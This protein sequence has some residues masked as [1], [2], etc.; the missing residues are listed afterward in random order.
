MRRNVKSSCLESRIMTHVIF[1][2]A[3]S[4][5][6]LFDAPQHHQTQFRDPVSFYLCSRTI[7][8]LQRRPGWLLFRSFRH[9]HCYFSPEGLLQ[10]MQPCAVVCIWMIP[11]GCPSIS[12]STILIY[13][14]HPSFPCT[15]RLLLVLILHR[16]AGWSAECLN[17]YLFAAAREISLELTTHPHPSMYD[18]RD[19]CVSYGPGVSQGGCDLGGCPYSR[20][21]PRSI[22]AAECVWLILLFPL[23]LLGMA[24]AYRAA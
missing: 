14:Q 9:A 10:I 23:S 12:D 11:F 2:S 24:L 13:N 19:F 8:L 3:P 17:I 7:S 16:Y 20:I 22:L 21:K 6:A 5:W 1:L 15:S 18:G 4:R